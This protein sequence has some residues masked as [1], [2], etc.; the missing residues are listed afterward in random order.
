MLD[1][2]LRD[3]TVEGLISKRQR[4]GGALDQRHP[5]AAQ[6]AQ[7]AEIEVHPNGVVEALYD[8]AG[9][10]AR[11]EDALGAARPVHGEVMAPSMPETLNRGDAIEAALVVVRRC[12]RVAQLPHR[13]GRTQDVGA[14][15]HQPDVRT[16]YRAREVYERDL[17][18]AEAASVSANQDLFLHLE[19]LRGDLHPFERGAA[20]EPKPAG[21]VT[22]RHREHPAQQDVQE[23]AG[24]SQNE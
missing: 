20:V 7:L 9:T 18:H 15:S 11:V 3:Q 8:E 1:D 13:E 17:D 5:V 16:P 19:V 23:K 4:E 24:P 21:D 22:Y 12:Q 14:E 2:L 6:K 10:A